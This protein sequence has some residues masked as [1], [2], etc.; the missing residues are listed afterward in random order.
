MVATAVRLLDHVPA[1]PSVSMDVLPIQS[2]AA[3]VMLPGS[4]F[5][6]TVHVWAHP[7]TG[8]V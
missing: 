5:T 8:K 3:P 1:P 7:V 2:A 6:V 4:G